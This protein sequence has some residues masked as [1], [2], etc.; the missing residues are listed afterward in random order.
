[1]HVINFKTGDLHEVTKYVKSGDGSGEE[2][3]WCNSWYGR[4]VIGKDCAIVKSFQL[5]TTNTQ[6]DD[7][8]G[9]D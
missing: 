4:H 1:M 3:V 9:K 7:T 8:T 2:S 5:N 6:K